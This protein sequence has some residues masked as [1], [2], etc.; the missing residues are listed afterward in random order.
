MRI[1]GGQIAVGV[2]EAR[3]FLE[4]DQLLRY[5]L[6]EASGNEV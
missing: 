3:I 1:A 5:R 4:S 6:F 2:W